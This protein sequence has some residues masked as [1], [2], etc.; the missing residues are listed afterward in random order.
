MKETLPRCLQCGENPRFVIGCSEFGVIDYHPLCRECDLELREKSG[1]RT[2]RHTDSVRPL[3]LLELT[4]IKTRFLALGAVMCSLPQFLVMFIKG[5][6]IAVVVHSIL[7]G[8]F[9]PWAIAG[10]WLNRRKA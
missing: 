10:F 9:A 4:V 2:I 5:P 6:L 3:N 1:L 8:I 7:L